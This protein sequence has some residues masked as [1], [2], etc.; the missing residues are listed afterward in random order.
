MSKTENPDDVIIL[1]V[2]SPPSMKNFEKLVAKARKQKI[3]SGIKKIDVLKSIKKVRK[4]TLTVK[5]RDVFV[6]ALLNPPAP[7]EKLIKAA[8]KYKKNVVSK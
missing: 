1:K 5:D 3:Q 6:R 7:S 2:I 4:K 8:K